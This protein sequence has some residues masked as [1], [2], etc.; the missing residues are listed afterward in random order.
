MGVKDN[1]AVDDYYSSLNSGSAESDAVP[2]K[3]KLKL[4]PKK[5]VIVKK[6]VKP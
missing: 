2:K 4:K 3:K 5:K 6:V 1:N